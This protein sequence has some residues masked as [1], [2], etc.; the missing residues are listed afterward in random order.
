ME[1]LG[2]PG[3]IHVSEAVTEAL[4]GRFSFVERGW[5]D[6]RGAGRMR[7]FFLGDPTERRPD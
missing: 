7:T 2:E 5:I 6:V 4:A 1:S 3:R